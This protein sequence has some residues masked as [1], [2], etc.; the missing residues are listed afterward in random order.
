MLVQSVTDEGSNVDQGREQFLACVFI[1]G[2]NE[3]KFEGYRKKLADD[4][5]GDQVSRHPETVEDAVAVMHANL[6]N[7]NDDVR[8]GAN[9]A[10]TMAEL[11][12]VT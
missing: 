7:H 12:R 10:Q 2:S 11:S 4:C 6:D 1:A 5:A 8:K 3:S 9:F